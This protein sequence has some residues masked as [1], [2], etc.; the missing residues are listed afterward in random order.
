LT[1]VYRSPDAEF[2]S[3]VKK[4][5]KHGYKF[6]KDPVLGDRSFWI[7]ALEFVRTKGYKV[8]QPRKSYHK[9]GMG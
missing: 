8:A 7:G 9:K 1:S 3:I 4:A 6:A 2:S 5:R